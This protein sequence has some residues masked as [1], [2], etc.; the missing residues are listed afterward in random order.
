MY[1]GSPLNQSPW[2]GSP[3][4]PMVSTPVQ[5]AILAAILGRPLPAIP[6]S[7]SPTPYLVRTGGGLSPQMMS[8][9]GSQLGNWQTYRMGF[10]PNQTNFGW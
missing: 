6:G 7:T 5:A 8:G 1:Y 4:Y 9:Y 10:E 3:Y 2:G